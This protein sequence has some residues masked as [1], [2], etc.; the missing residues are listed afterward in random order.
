MVPV[1][2]E[3]VNLA[4]LLSTGI[5][6]IRYEGLRQVYLCSVQNR[7]LITNIADIRPAQETLNSTLN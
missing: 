1:K 7:G 3:N 2:F 4:L 6:Y 5:Q